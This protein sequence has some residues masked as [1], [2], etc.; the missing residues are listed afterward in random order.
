MPTKKY[1]CSCPHCGKP[2]EFTTPTKKKEK[3][4]EK[5]QVYTSCVDYWLKT[6]HPGW[7][8]GAIQGQH[9][10]QLLSKMKTSLLEGKRFV[11]S[12]SVHVNAFQYFCHHLPD[13]FKDKDLQV[14]NSKYNEIIEQMKKG[15]TP[16]HND[17]NSKNSAARFN[18]AANRYK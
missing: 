14:L 15:V 1:T 4:I 12:E 16:Q 5:S 18:E 8:F 17:F 10:K 13:Y 7:T 6:V 9:L 11:Y 2:F 3:A